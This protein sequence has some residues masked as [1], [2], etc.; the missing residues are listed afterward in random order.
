MSTP[1]RKSL[2]PTEQQHSKDNDPLRSPDVP[3]RAHDRSPYAPKR[4][5]T[6]TTTETGFIR[7]E[8]AP[9]LAP[10]HAPEDSREHSAARRHAAAI[11][12]ANDA[13]G[14]ARAP[15]MPLPRERDDHSR[16]TAFEDT[17]ASRRLVAP[18]P[19]TSLQPAHPNSRPEIGLSS[20]RRDKAMSD[21]DRLE[22]VLRQFVREQPAARLPRAAQ[23]PPV[24]GLHPIGEMSLD[25]ERLVPP[26]AIMSSGDRA[27][28]PLGILI[29]GICALPID[30]FEC[31]LQSPA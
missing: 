26:A 29:A 20:T 21:L 6:Q 1:T 31:E 10:P 23:L 7:N 8:D 15:A 30:M 24:S 12:Y 4:G 5:R 3:T 28:W 9:P 14:H 11:D 17:A 19:A 22:A 16:M 2:G 27:R 13:G 25:P 18:D